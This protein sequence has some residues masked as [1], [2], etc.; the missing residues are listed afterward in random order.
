MSSPPRRAM[1][2]TASPSSATA[3]K[4]PQISADSKSRP[5][6]VATSPSRTSLT[7]PPKPSSSTPPVRFKPASRSKP[8]AKTPEPSLCR[9]PMWCACPT[10]SPHSRSVSSC[11]KNSPLL[12][13]PFGAKYSTA[14]TASQP[15]RA[16]FCTRSG[17]I[18]DFPAGF[19]LFRTAHHEKIRNFAHTTCPSPLPMV[20]EGKTPAQPF[21]PFRSQ[22]GGRCAPST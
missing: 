2:H 4:P 12:N 5:T 22:R 15:M 21:R 19:R 16:V 8:A 11:P 6:C 1:R 17:S 3:R 10:R 7:N 9:V 18:R 20:R 13:V 14:R